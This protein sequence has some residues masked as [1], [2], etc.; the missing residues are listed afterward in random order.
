MQGILILIFVIL[1]V[2]VL[3]KDIGSESKNQRRETRTCSHCGMTIPY[4]ASVCPYCRRKPGSDLRAETR[5]MK[6][7]FMFKFA[8][9][10]LGLMA[11]CFS[12]MVLLSLAGA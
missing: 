8:V 1:L 4:R 3:L 6:N 12:L 7:S 9:G 2:G 5:L 10:A 11:V